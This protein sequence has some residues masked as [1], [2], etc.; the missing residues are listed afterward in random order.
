M[1]SQA[2]KSDN[3][4]ALALKAYWWLWVSISAQVEALGGLCLLIVAIIS[5]PSFVSSKSAQER[6]FYLLQ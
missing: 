6:S 1:C 5:S 2:M 3:K 4:K